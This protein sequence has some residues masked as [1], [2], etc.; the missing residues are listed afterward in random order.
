MELPNAL[1]DEGEKGFD[2]VEEEAP[3]TAAKSCRVNTGMGGPCALSGRLPPV[4]CRRSMRST[5]IIPIRLIPRR[6]F[7]SPF[8][9]RGR[10][11]IVADDL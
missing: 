11:M 6:S 1:E 3:I 8:P 2:E 4:L 7:L 10:G 5:L 9:L